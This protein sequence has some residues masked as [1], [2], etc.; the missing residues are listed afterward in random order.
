MSRSTIIALK[1]LTHVLCLLPFVWLLHFYTSGALALNPDPVNY[2]T[3]FTGDWAVYT[4][5]ACLI[6]TPLRRLSP[7]I[8]WFIRF[9]RL[10]GLYAFFYASLHLATYI[11]LFSGYDLPTVLTGIRAGHP[12]IAVEEWKQ[13]WPTILGD[14]LKRRFIQ[15]G[16]VAWLILLALAVTSPAFIMRAMGGKNWQRLHRLIYVA[17]AA[18]MI[19]YWWLVKTG[20][21]TPWKDTAVLTVLLVARAL[22]SAYKR[23]RRPVPALQPTRN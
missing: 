7:K 4:L 6:I 9:R 17:G 19:H 8:A 14:V 20:V 3:H 21:R 2:I 1:F 13:I 23:L 5:L 18:A 22:Y 12:G 16:F 11:F 15:V 10:I